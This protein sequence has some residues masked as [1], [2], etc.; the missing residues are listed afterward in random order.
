ML[1]QPKL[2]RRHFNRQGTFCRAVG[3]FKAAIHQFARLEIESDEDNNSLK[4]LKSDRASRRQLASRRSYGSLPP[5]VRTL[6]RFEPVIM[7]I[8]EQI[9][10]QRAITRQLWK[11]W[12]RVRRPRGEVS[13]R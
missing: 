2:P 11:R 12:L 8:V 3:R 5:N 13:D 9:R 1:S 7:L 10:Q 6:L 4:I